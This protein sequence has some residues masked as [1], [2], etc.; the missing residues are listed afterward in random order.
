MKAGEKDFGF[1][2]EGMDSADDA[3]YSDMTSDLSVVSG[4]ATVGAHPRSPHK[5]YKNSHR[6]DNSNRISL[7]LPPVDKE[8]SSPDSDDTQNDNIFSFMRTASGKIALNKGTSLPS[9]L[10]GLDESC[11]CHCGACC[12]CHS[13]ENSQANCYSCRPVCKKLSDGSECQISNSKE[14]C[15]LPSPTAIES[16]GHFSKHRR[17]NYKYRRSNYSSSSDDDD[18]DNA[19]SA[20][21]RTNSQMS[22][23]AKQKSHL[24]SITLMRQSSSASTH[25]FDKSTAGSLD[26][27]SKEGV[28]PV[29]FKERVKVSKKL[30]I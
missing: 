28:K 4:P 19:A 15:T 10:K 25:S 30:Y 17:S 9:K 26:L 13:D 23:L 18:D 5:H 6:H 24:P 2:F 27:T 20:R 1:Q 8:N 3:Y 22:L 14:H 29:H 11:Q 16:W 12:S 7:V 21:K